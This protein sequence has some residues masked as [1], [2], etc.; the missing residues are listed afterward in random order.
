M[1][2]AEAL[3]DVAGCGIG[4]CEIYSSS[5][6]TLLCELEK[7]LYVSLPDDNC[8]RDFSKVYSLL[9]HKG[10]PAARRGRKASG[11]MAQVR[12]I[13]GLP[14]RGSAKRLCRQS[15][16]YS[17]PHSGPPGVLA[18]ASSSDVSARVFARC[19]GC[20]GKWEQRK[21]KRANPS[22]GGD[23]KPP[24]YRTSSYDSG[25]T[26]K[27][28]HTNAIRE[29]TRAS[30][31]AAFCVPVSLPVHNAVARHCDRTVSRPSKT[32]YVP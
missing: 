16:H 25:V 2:P 1:Q 27:E 30:T 13:A 5:V 3:R 15:F 29:F 7:S 12:R 6:L 9:L 24:V 18:K 32:R 4:R 11:P 28:S 10:K 19:S 26:S 8:N 20:L 21:L 14:G 23:A 17:R 22:K 31:V